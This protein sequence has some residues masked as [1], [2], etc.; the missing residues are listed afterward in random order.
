MKINELKELFLRQVN[1]DSI[2]AKSIDY[3]LKYLPSEISYKIGAPPS[4]RGACTSKY[5]NSKLDFEL[6][7]VI[8]WLTC[9]FSYFKLQQFFI[10]NF[11]SF[12]EFK[13]LF[14]P[15]Y[16]FKRKF[17]KDSYHFLETG[18]INLG[19]FE[20]SHRTTL[21]ELTGSSLE[22]FRQ[23]FQCTD[24][25]I[26]KAINYSE[27][28]NIIDSDSKITRIDLTIDFVSHDIISGLNLWDNI[29]IHL[30]KKLFTTKTNDQNIKMLIKGTNRDHI[31]TVYIGSRKSERYMCIYLKH[32]ESLDKYNKLMDKFIIRFELRLSEKHAYSFRMNCE[33]I[34]CEN[35]FLK[36]MKSMIND[37]IQF[38]EIKKHHVI[39][40]KNKNR[41][42]IA[43]FWSEIFNNDFKITNYPI[44]KFDDYFR[45]RKQVEKSSLGFYKML[46]CEDSEADQQNL[47]RQLIDL[48]RTKFESKLENNLD[49]LNNF[50]EQIKPKIIIGE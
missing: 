26:L 29:L 12:D 3:Y 16:L 44:V 1:S 7:C 2:V 25:Q 10:G 6:N 5:S 43:P 20:S 24:L 34:V 33:N 30:E 8:D 35:E 22:R 31:Q 28:N 4:N 47:I 13:A 49:Q 32:E 15:I 38:K 19:N 48:G 40:K 18:S 39:D 21:L 37:F 50:R 46:Q 41:L 11:C 23:K 45:T 14:N 17:Y 27:G 42:S 36:L 9:S